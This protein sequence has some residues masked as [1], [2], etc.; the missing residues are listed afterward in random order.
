MYAL[1]SIFYLQISLALTAQQGC[2]KVSA[3]LKQILHT[4]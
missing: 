1:F 3:A 2:L 4:R